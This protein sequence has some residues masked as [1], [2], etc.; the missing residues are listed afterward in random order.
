MEEEMLEW[1]RGRYLPFVDTKI[2]GAEIHYEHLHRYYVAS[3]FVNDKKILDQACGEG[4]GSY[5]LSKSAEHIVGMDIDELT[6]KHASCKYEE[7]H[8]TRNKYIDY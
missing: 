8:D 3:H 5:I 2:C 4:Y 1:T 6:I 7:D